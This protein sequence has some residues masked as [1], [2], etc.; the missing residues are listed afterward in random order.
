MEFRRGKAKKEGETDVR[1]LFMACSPLRRCVR[2]PL[3]H[4]NAG[5]SHTSGAAISN[6]FFGDIGW[7]G[8]REIKDSLEMRTGR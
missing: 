5:V 6:T 2:A 4:Q 3:R 1:K 7:V 8:R